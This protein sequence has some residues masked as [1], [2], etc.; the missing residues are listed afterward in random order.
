MRARLLPAAALLLALAGCGDAILFAELDMPSVQV[1]LAKQTFFGTALPTTSTDLS[2]DIG[3][4]V[5]IVNE[6]NVTVDMTLT[7]MELVLDPA[8]PANPANFDAIDTV[9]I[10]ALA[11]AGSGLTDLVLLNYTKAAGATGITHIDAASSTSADLT[12]Y[13]Q[14]GAINLRA[15]Y[16]G[17]GLPTADWTADVTAEFHI[18]VKMDYG[19][20]L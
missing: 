11:P 1:T 12:P 3:T 7:S 20:Y 6:P 9:T 10:E 2:F 8:N 17:T 16:S 14:A 19:A 5:P 13:L 4:N 18:K 15:S